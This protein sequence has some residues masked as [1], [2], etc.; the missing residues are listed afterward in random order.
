MYNINMKRFLSRFSRVGLIIIAV[1]LV[2]TLLIPLW[3]LISPFSCGGFMC[4]LSDNLV[5]FILLNIP[6]WLLTGLQ[7]TQ[8]ALDFF[9]PNDVTLSGNLYFTDYLFMFLF[10]STTYYILGSLFELLI[11]K[12]RILYTSKIKLPS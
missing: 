3:T 5:Y 2:L 6:G 7:V 9:R 8:E 11:K 12:I 4:I 10:S 1:H